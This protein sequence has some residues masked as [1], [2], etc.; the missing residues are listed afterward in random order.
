MNLFEELKLV[1]DNFD[2]DGNLISADPYGEGH[3][4]RTY[5]AVYDVLGKQKRYI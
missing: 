1:L 5:L 4:N 2:I 3:I